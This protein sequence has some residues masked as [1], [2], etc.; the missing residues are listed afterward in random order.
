MR[1]EQR[2]AGIEGRLRQSDRL[3]LQLKSL[4]PRAEPAR[5]NA[6]LRQLGSALMYLGGLLVLWVVLFQLGLALGLG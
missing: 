4:G 6:R 1:L 2:I 5:A 3:I